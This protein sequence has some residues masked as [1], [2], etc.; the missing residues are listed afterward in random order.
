MNQTFV[1][2][3]M[4]GA[5]VAPG[6]L[7]AQAPVASPFMIDVISS[8]APEL[9]ERPRCDV[10]AAVPYSL[11][12]FVELDTGNVAEY[13]LS[14]IIRDSTGRKLVDSLYRRTI[15]EDE[16]AVTRGSTGAA[17]NSVR[18]YRLP[19]GTYRMELV[20]RDV[21]GKRDFSMSQ[22]IV[23]PVFPEQE[24]SM[25]SVMLVREV[26]QRGSRYAI[27]P[28]IG[29][30][31]WSKDMQLFAFV[32]CYVPRGIPRVGLQWSITA[33]D[34]REVASGL[35]EPV[36][37]SGSS[38]QAFVPLSLPQ[39]MLPG[40]FQLRLRLHTSDASGSIDTT[41]TLAER[42][43]TI[44]IPRSS[45]GAVLNDLAKAIRQLIYVADQADIDMINAGTTD[46]EKIV[47][48][49]DFW[50]RLDPTPSTVRNEAFEAFYDRI[51]QAN[52]RFKSYTEGWLT[53]MG[54]V[55]V[56][57]GEP[58]QVDRFSTQSGMS[59]AIR[60]TYPNNLM[61]TFEDASGFGDFRLRTPM[62]AGAKYRYRR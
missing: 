27:T 49:D 18:R 20:L 25:S 33:P 9:L 62:P 60:W 11:L 34:N 39:R 6:A 55:F 47:Q 46:A 1:A 2:I 17:D 13:T 19:S 48:F 31:I 43:R 51:E 24:A 15:I 58:L 38:T 8:R 41:S 50:K 57:Y 23:V 16:V 42:S 44:I 30:V 53:D 14:T 35:G 26:E 45:S 7:L 61:F 56:I 12:N 29:D 54:R 59:V 22:K 3:G 32:D 4:L 37:V 10:Y 5:V 21:F 36:D 40:T 28:F 52:Q